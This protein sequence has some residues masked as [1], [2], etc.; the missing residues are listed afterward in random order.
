[1]GWTK[2]NSQTMSLATKH[3]ATV[4]VGSVLV[5]ALSF[6][7][8]TPAKADLLSDLQAQVQA[9]LAQITA[10]G[11]GSSTTAGAGCYA[12]TTTHQQGQSGGEIMWIQKFL[13]SHGAQVAASGAGSPGNETSYYGALTKA[14]VA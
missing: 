6:A 2:V 9:L 5:L 1:M 11:G 4:L 3:V 10:L 12:F 7:F 13:N 14:G 8:V